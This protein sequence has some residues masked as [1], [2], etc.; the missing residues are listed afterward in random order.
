MR[1][2]TRL[3]A[4]TALAGLV[5]FG[6]AGALL[7]REER[8]DLRAAVSREV[9]FLGSSLRV[10]V[11]NAIRDRQLADVQETT[12][13]VEGVDTD[14]DVLVFDP[15]GAPVAAPSGMPQGDLRA[16]LLAVVGEA[17]RAG[18]PRMSWR[19]AEAPRAILYATPLLSDDGDALGVLAL[20]RPID[21]VN[22]DLLETSGS[23]AVTVGAFV[24]LA[25][26]LGLF[27]GRTWLGR[28]L[29]RLAGAMR[30]VREGDFA[31]SLP[32]QG[33]D[34]VAGLAAEFNRMLAELRSARR[35]AADE[36]EARREATHSLQAANRLVTVGQLSAA[37]AH[38]IGSPLQVLHGRA[39]ALAERPEDAERTRRHAEVLVRESERITRIVAQLLALTRRRAPRREEVDV[40]GAAR[41]VLGLLEI[42]ARRRGV[43]VEVESFGAV[44]IE[45]DPDQIQQVLLNLATN[46]LAAARP[47]GSVLVRVEGGDGGV[48]IVVEDDGVGMT[49]EVRARV[50]EPLFTT[51]EDQGGTGLGLAVVRGIVHEHGGR[52]SCTSTPGEGAR[53]TVELP[54]SPS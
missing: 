49:E 3:T 35:A 23:I 32:E 36:A 28:P 20:V 43:R 5:V 39:R 45:A 22:E 37:V 33:D 40:A 8:E 24:L 13:R 51:R 42:E 12:L 4:T 27:V 26:A 17:A 31:P 11:E 52:V 14:V 21:D 9:T 2:V 18:E 50:F 30:K 6:V 16:D 41:D 47:D 29:D 15:N 34:E 19:P 46:A 25:S 1:L 38:E 53:F 44:H 10:G 7:V 48:R 54:R